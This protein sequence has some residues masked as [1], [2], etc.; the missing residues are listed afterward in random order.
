MFNRIDGAGV[1]WMNQTRT[2]LALIGVCLFQA[3][4]V[5]TWLACDHHGVLRRSDPV[6]ASVEA[7]AGASRSQT[8]ELHA[9]PK[10][11]LAARVA[12]LE[13]QRPKLREHKRTNAFQSLEETRFARVGGIRSAP[14][15]CLAI[16]SR[17]AVSTHTKSK[18]AAK[19]VGLES[20]VR[21]EA[22]SANAQMLLN[23]SK[24]L[25]LFPRE[26]PST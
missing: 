13:S 10:F 22:L 26:L 4:L 5:I 9:S 8:K 7:V 25:D 23:L 2:F 3:L 16:A 12:G 24:K 20:Q 11:K 14:K 6:E 18:L 17:V 15:G 1:V 19:V 21:A